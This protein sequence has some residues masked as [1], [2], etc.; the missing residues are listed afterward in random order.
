MLLQACDANYLLILRLI[1]LP[2][3]V[4]IVKY[5][6]NL[7]DHKTNKHMFPHVKI[8]SSQYESAHC[9]Q[10]IKLIQYIASTY[11]TTYTYIYVYIR[12]YIYKVIY[13]SVVD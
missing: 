9:F 12:I 2:L 5:Y 7:D 13:I 3:L 10:V 1:S 4:D 8:I 6:K 11:I